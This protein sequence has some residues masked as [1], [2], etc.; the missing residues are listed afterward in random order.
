MIR[1]KMEQVVVSG[2]QGPLSKCPGG[3]APMPV[4]FLVAYRAMALVLLWQHQAPASLISHNAIERSII[5]KGAQGRHWWCSLPGCWDISNYAKMMCENA[6]LGNL[7]WGLVILL[8]LCISSDWL[9][10][11]SHVLQRCSGLSHLTARELEID[12]AQQWIIKTLFTCYSH[13][14][15]SCAVQ[16]LRSRQETSI[17]CWVPTSINSASMNHG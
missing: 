17:Y 8:C 11:P 2:W 13:V 12:K 7:P 14:R 10:D 5:F 4:H 16:P 1:E 3:L 15:H 9:T 6:K